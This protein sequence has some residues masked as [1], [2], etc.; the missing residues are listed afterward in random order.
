MLLNWPPGV[1]LRVVLA[2]SALLVAPA[3]IDVRLTFGPGADTN[4]FQLI[5]CS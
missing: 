2:S 1:R 5:P 4:W 3:V